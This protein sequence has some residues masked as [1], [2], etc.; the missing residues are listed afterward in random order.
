VGVC[1]GLYD[2]PIV[3][4]SPAAPT[5]RPA[6]L[7]N[8]P[9]PSRPADEPH[10]S[11]PRVCEVGRTATVPAWPQSRQRRTGFVTLKAPGNG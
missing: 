5:P 10:S 6:S 11:C 8:T 3:G 9:Y 7:P 1:P 4:V 2:D